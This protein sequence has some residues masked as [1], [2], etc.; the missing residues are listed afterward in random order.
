MKTHLFALLLLLTTEFCLAQRDGIVKSSDSS[1]IYYKTFGAGEPLL[2]VNGG[3]GM[4]SEGFEGLAR[5]L[6]KNNLTI[7]YDQRGTGKSVILKPDASNITMKLMMDDM[8][9]LRKHL[10]IEKW[11]ILGH[12]F[13]GM[14]TSYYATQY[15]DRIEKIILSSS[16]GVD[17]GLF[18]DGGALINSRLSKSEL[19]SMNYWSEKIAAGD[20]SY[21]AM[22]GRARNLAPAYVYD[23]KNIPVIA[24]RLT[25]G[26]STV[27]QLMWENLQ[28]IK[29]DCSEQLKSFKQ[30]VLIIQGKQDILKPEVA[31]KSHQ[32]FKNSKLVWLD[33]C[34]HYGWLDNEDVYFKEIAQFLSS[35]K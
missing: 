22:M 3:P 2:I 19:D 20:K 33:H 9:S 29:F 32:A 12:S 10:N 26:N 28:A 14:I 23:R 18:S 6:S 34:G 27:N 13:G 16:G 25:Q 24:E 35:K 15:P 11:S 21:R 8:E 1:P 7:I 5:T 17:L 31:E 4:N 30:P